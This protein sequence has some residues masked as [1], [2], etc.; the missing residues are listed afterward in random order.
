MT[1][2]QQTRFRFLISQCLI[3]DGGMLSYDD[4]VVAKAY[5]GFCPEHTEHDRRKQFRNDCNAIIKH[6]K[7]VKSSILEP[8][9]LPTPSIE[10]TSKTGRLRIRTGRRPVVVEKNRNPEQT[11]DRQAM[12]KHVLKST[13]PDNPKLPIVP[14]SGRIYAGF[15]TTMCFLIRELLND[16]NQERRINSLVVYTAST[17]IMGQMYYLHERASDNESI[18]IAQ[19]LQVDRELGLYRKLDEAKVTVDTAIFSYSGLQNGDFFSFAPQ[20]YRDSVKEYIEKAE[21]IV[22][23]LDAGKIGK[24]GRG[25]SVPLPCEGKKPI[26][27]VSTAPLEKLDQHLPKGVDLLQRMQAV[28]EK[29]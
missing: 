26:L 8:F 2:E 7:A 27:V 24:N 10:F 19:V 6:Y 20:D 29:S 5:V 3:Q 22:I 18:R 23:L 21:R 15:G 16:F 25:V 28:D 13:W 9:F 14:R 4:E 1:E 17:E 12:V 11:A